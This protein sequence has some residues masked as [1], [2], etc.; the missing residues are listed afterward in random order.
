MGQDG[1]PMSIVVL[2]LGFFLGVIA[3]VG[4]IIAMIFSAP[5]A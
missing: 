3:I 1:L 5:P 2:F 4:I